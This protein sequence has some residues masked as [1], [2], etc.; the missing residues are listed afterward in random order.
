MLIN[1]QPATSVSVSDRGLAYGDGVFETFRIAAGGKL[2]FEDLHLQRLSLGCERLGIALTLD[3]VKAE[4]A[5]ALELRSAQAE[6][7]KLIVTRGVSGRGYR[8]DISNASTRIIT[9]HTLPPNNQIH[10]EQG[11]KAFICSQRLCAQPALAGIKHLNRLEQVLASR[12]WPDETYQEGIML[13]MEGN[14]VEGTRSNIFIVDGGDI[15]TD[16]LATC[17]ISGVMRQ[18]L[19]QCFGDR[20]NVGKFNLQQLYA[21]DEVFF[22]NSIFGVWPLRHLISDGIEQHYVPGPVAMAARSIFNKGFIQ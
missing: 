21:A 19:L 1:G 14:V 10:A 17:G 6:I 4:L 8:P 9:L 2:L 22:C 15:M 5:T 16:S 3:Q 18:I 11:I 13:D 7:L 20:L 12:E